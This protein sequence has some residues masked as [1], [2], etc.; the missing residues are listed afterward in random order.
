MLTCT[1]Q[2]QAQGQSA[3]RIDAPVVDGLSIQVVTDGNHDI[4]ISGAQ[5]P[6]VRVERVRGFRGA[7]ERRAL[8]SEHGLSLY[9]TPPRGDQT[10]GLLPDFGWA[11][12]TPDHNLALLG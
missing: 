2:A 3:A 10:R 1:R 4:F 9:P 11:P 5:V 6:G 12:G 8:K 7:L